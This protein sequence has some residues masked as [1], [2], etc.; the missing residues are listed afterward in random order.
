MTTH[1]V[2]DTESP[3]IAVV[4]AVAD[5]NGIDP[6]D[7]E[8][9]LYDHIDPGAL[10]TLLD[11]VSSETGQVSVTF[12]MAGCRVTIDSTGKIIVTHLG[13]TDPSLARASS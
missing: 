1:T 11:S 13:D 8:A 6:V 10:D 5:A 9:C 4:T 3:S 2:S 12:E 7:L